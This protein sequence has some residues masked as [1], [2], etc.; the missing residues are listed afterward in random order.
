MT[1]RLSAPFDDRGKAA[2][3]PLRRQRKV[4]LDAQTFA[5]EVIQHVEQPELPAIAKAIGHEVHRPDC[6]RGVRHGQ[7]IRL[8]PL[9]P[10][11]GLDPQV[12]LK[13]A[14]DPVNPFVVPDAPLNVAQIQEAQAE[15]LG[16]P[17][18]GQPDQQIGDL[19]VLAAPLRTVAVTTFAYPEGPAGRRDADPSPRHRG[20]GHLSA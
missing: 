18:V 13:L 12:Q 6:V 19:V 17:G 2:D 7:R 16:L 9:Q 10:F 4:D 15:P 5:V 8:V 11:A 20:H 1:A 3:D 14:G